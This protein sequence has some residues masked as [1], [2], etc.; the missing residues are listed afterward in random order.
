MQATPRQD[1]KPE[2]ALRRELHRLGLRYY[3]HRRPLPELRRE[4]DI[5]F[6]RAKIAVFVDSCFWHG[7]PEHV[8]WP[9]A[10]ADW[11]R[12]KIERTRRRDADTNDRLARVG[13]DAVRVWEHEDTALAAR[14]IHKQ[15][16]Q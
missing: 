6:P 7:C 10:N 2:L 13:W 5:V 16:I 1:T 11:W 15:V 8:T 9:A 14:R 4:A 12:E 3:V